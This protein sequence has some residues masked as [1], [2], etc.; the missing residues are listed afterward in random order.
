LGECAHSDA[1]P[2]RRR[3]AAGLFA[4]A[5]PTVES[6]R[7]PRAWAFT[8]L[9]LDAYC[10][11]VPK[12]S[13]AECVRTL[14]ADRLIAILSLVETKI[15]VVRGRAC[16]RQRAFASSP[17]HYGDFYRS[18]RLCRGRPEVLALAHDG[19]DDAGGYFRPIGTESFGDKRTPPR[20]FDQ[21]PLEPRRRSQP[22]LRLCA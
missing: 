16:L 18:I 14:L 4:E 2:S 12:D 22:A 15:G 19:T 7:S 5:L 21:Q 17:D 9:G 10:A 3:W 6:F 11:A 8:L 20:A 13:L 1:S